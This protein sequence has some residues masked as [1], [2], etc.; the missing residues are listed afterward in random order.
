MFADSFGSKDWSTESIFSWKYRRGSFFFDRNFSLDRHIKDCG[1]GS[2]RG[3]LKFGGWR[4]RI[5]GEK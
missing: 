3:R 5:Q 2:R 4:L 1:A